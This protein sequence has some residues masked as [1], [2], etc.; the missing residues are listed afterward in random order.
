MNFVLRPS[1][2]LL[3]ALAGWINCQQGHMVEYLIT[4]NQVLK[5]KLEKNVFL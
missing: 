4:E 5:E 2:L 1:Q 3:V